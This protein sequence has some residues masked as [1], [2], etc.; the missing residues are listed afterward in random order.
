MKNINTSLSSWTDSSRMPVKKSVLEFIQTAHKETVANAIIGL[1]GDSY[2]NTEV[3]ILWGIDYNGVT[4]TVSDG[5]VFYNGEVLKYNS[6]VI[7]PPFSFFFETNVNE[8]IKFSDGSNREALVENYVSLGIPG[9]GSLG[10]GIAV[11]NLFDLYTTTVKLSGNQAIAGI[12]TFSSFPLTPSSAPTTNYQTSNKKYVD[13]SVSGAISTASSD[14]TSKAN[15]AQSNAESFVGMQ[16]VWSATVTCNNDNTFSASIHKEITGYTGATISN[17]WGLLV[18]SFPTT[19]SRNSYF[20]IAGANNGTN[21]FIIKQ[22]FITNA[23]D[24]KI[25]ILFG[26]SV[27]TAYFDVQLIKLN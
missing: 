14:A 15:A 11:P 8:V 5:A 7:S 26:S 20:V 22:T 2:S 13:D 23:P 24:N 3:Y 21:D 18:I 17:S 4:G 12:K 10:T 19:I 1:I 27:G 9:V 25:N 16:I 6:Q